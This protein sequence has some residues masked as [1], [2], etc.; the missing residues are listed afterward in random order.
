MKNLA[1]EFKAFVLRGNMVDLA[2]G[3][4]IGL[5]FAAVV[6]SL[7]NTLINPLVG[8]I[9][10]GAD[11]SGKSFTI[12]GSTFGYGLFLT[13]VLTFLVTALAVFL[14]VVKPVNALMARAKT[15]P[16]ADP[17]EKQCPECLSLIPVEARR[18]AHCTVPLAA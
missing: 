14:F 2:V 10:P 16:P 7:V 17:T 5:A 11:L 9:L 18:C 15:E 4:V 8:L 13:Q 1:K 3:L 6:I 12:A